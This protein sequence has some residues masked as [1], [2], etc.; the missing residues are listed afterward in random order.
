MSCESY[1][2]ILTPIPEHWDP[3]ATVDGLF[4]MKLKQWNV[5]LL[6]DLFSP[7]KIDLIRSLPLSI[8]DVEDR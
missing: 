1:F 6:Y 3:K 8:R 4:W 7:E 5:P 2:R